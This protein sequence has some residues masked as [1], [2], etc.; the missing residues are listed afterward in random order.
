METRLMPGFSCPKLLRLQGPWEIRTPNCL[1]WASS[2][3]PSEPD[4]GVSAS[5]GV[6][7]GALGSDTLVLPW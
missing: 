4:Q 3:G 1:D 5:M 6:S 7:H 2:L